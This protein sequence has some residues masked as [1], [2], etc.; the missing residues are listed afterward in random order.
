MATEEP[1]F[2]LIEK[3][4]DFELRLYKPMIVAETY[5]EGSLSE[6]SSAG[7]R[8]IA[9]YIFGG[10]KSRQGSASESIAMTAPVTLEPS[11][12]NIKM[13]APVVVESTGNR[14]RVQF[15]MPAGYTLNSLPI[16]NDSRVSLREIPEQKTAVI[17]FSG[18]AGDEKV[19]DKTA[20][21]Q[22]WMKSRGLVATSNP[23]LARYNP[24][25]TLPFLRRNEI[26]INIQ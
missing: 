8:L 12:Q 21:L 10:N 5:V 6:A 24:P 18:F 9:G 2:G 22:N 11:P 17:E 15:V 1:K 16:P 4:G 25:W 7:F 14:W 13:T 20:I 23:Q 19:K 26:L 3:N